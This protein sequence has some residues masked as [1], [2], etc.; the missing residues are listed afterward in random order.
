MTLPL[1]PPPALPAARCSIHDGLGGGVLFDGAGTRGRL[2]G[3]DIK[4]N[5][6]V[7]VLIRR[8]AD[9]TLCAN[10]IH[11]GGQE[12]VYVL[13]SGAKGRLEG[14]E[15]WGNEGGGVFVTLGGD[16]TLV[17]NTIRDHARWRLLPHSGS[18]LFV[19]F[20]ARG[21]A[22]LGVGNVFARNE[23]GDVVRERG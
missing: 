15:I 6:G 16:P 4:H 9:P 14:C 1:P 17:G 3:C 23:A 21:C 5:L 2:V 7:G 13:G 11:D 8:G 20:D 22:A 18:G 10:K 19:D 12:G